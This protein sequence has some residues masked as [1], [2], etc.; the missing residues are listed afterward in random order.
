M[1][2]QAMQPGVVMQ[3]AEGNVPESPAEGN[4]LPTR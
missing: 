3:P 2:G 1:P 4:A